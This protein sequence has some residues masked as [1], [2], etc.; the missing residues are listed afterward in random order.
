MLS[1]AAATIAT[2]T[3]AAKQVCSASNIPIYDGVNKTFEM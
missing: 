1:E 2:A 3:N